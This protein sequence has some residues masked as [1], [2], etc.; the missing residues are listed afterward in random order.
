MKKIENPFLKIGEFLVR[1]WNAKGLGSGNQELRQEL[2]ALS[3]GGK[4]AEKEYYARKIA[5]TLLVFVI[6]ICISAVVLLT[7]TQESR[8]VE[9]NELERPGYGMGSKE[10]ELTVQVE[11][12]SETELLT[13]TVQNQKYTSQQTDELLEKARQKL[14]QGLTGENASQ[15]EVRKP[16]WFPNS[17]EEG[18]VTVNW[19]TIPYGLIEDDGSLS[20]MPEE[21]GEVVEIQATLSCQGKDL[22]YETAVRVYPP[23]LSQK[24]QMW[25]EVQKKTDE[26][27]EKGSSEAVLKLPEE[28]NGRTLIWMRQPQ[29]SFSVVLALT[30]ILTLCVY[31]QSDQKIHKKAEERKNQML[32]DYPD[33]M[34]KMTMLLG[35]G[36]TI[37]GAFTR[38]ASEYKLADT[39]KIRYAYEE[40]LYACYEMK[41]GV[42]EGTAYENF[43]RRCQL[44]KYIKLGS[45]LSQNLK[46][47]SKGLASLLEKEA[48]S[49][50]EERKNMARK[51]GEQAGTKLLFP[52]ILMFGVV[53]VVLIVPAFLA[54]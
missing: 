39:G 5:D 32:M 49:S 42:S 22:V 13:V 14:E 46:K 16:L 2:T 37:R 29:H 1:K 27:D 15:D 10:E 34:W 48:A 52:M 9:K 38:I 30:L 17:L 33:I 3:A 43:G 20:G 41:S 47:G 12:E 25:R 35:A 11:G 40:M 28:I 50:M 26:A 44:P 45:I 6:G 53:L 19:M 7:E 31:L 24:E 18:A 4:N 36:L 23:M 51:L 54:F 21:T 8:S